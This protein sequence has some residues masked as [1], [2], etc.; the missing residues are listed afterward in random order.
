MKSVTGL[1]RHIIKINGKLLMFAAGIIGNLGGRKLGIHPA[2]VK[3]L[4]ISTNIC[5]R[6][7][8]ASE[9]K[10]SYTFKEAIMDWYKDNADKYL[11]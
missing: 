11:K 3:K 5:G 10:F 8:T 7:I 4:M 1:K 9:Y 2:R 6:K